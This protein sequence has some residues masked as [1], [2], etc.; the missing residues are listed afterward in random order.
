MPKLLTICVFAA[1]FCLAG[2]CKKS[3]V[4]LG[5]TVDCAP[6]SKIVKTVTN[7]EGVVSF[8]QA[9]QQYTILVHQPG[10]IDVVDVGIVCGTLPTSLQAVGTRVLISGTFKEYGQAPPTPVFIGYTYYYLAIT[11]LSPR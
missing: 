8:D 1:T 10:T 6:D 2:G 3:D 11:Q 9:Q 4:V 5:G 7:A